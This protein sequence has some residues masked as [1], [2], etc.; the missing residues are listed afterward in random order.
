MNCISI[1]YTLVWTFDFDDKYQFTSDGMR[2]N[3]KSGRKLKQCYNSGSIGY[4]INGKFMSLTKLR[5]HL[6]KIKESKVPF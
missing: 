6:T 4:N 2:F 5:N 3:V 1:N